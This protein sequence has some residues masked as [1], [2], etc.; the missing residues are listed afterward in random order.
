[1][2][3]RALSLLLLTLA[4]VG[5]PAMLAAQPMTS[6][7]L[8]VEKAAIVENQVHVTVKNVGKQTVVAWGVEARVKF[9]DGTSQW[10][11][12]TTDAY[13]APVHKS[14]YSSLL[15]PG[16]TY[17]LGL[18][19]QVRNP[20]DA[21]DVSAAPTVVV[22]D[23]DR[24]AGDERRV[25]Y[26]FQD[27]ARNEQVWRRIEAALVAA[28][29][30]STEPLSVLENLDAELESVDDKATRESLA[31]QEMRHKVS[32]AIRPDQFEKRSVGQRLTEL[33]SEV[34]SRRAA[35]EAHA[36]RRY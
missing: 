30:R 18:P 4:S 29:S 21:V 34:R 13:E 2:V 20:E 1:M 5:W 7:P 22:F 28:A 26:L 17:T 15:R 35:A 31:F 9:A 11:G 23:D 36:K 3:V 32:K 12:A 24:A 25:D 6:V 10:L 19:A 33:Q 16:G 14:P 27:R 8:V